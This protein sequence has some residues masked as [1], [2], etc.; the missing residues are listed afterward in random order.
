MAGQGAGHSPFSAR[1]WKAPLGYY[2]KRASGGLL[3]RAP[4]EGACAR[5][6]MMLHSGGVRP[7]AGASPSTGRAWGEGLQKYKERGWRVSRED[8][9]L[10]KKR[11]CRKLFA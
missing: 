6:G 1:P 2:K 10:S 9:E 7:R 8:W 11:V 3:R 4:L 5:S